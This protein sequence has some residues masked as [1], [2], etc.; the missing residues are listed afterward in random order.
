M[1]FNHYAYYITF[2]LSFS[3]IIIEQT[4]INNFPSAADE[5][6]SKEGAGKKRGNEI[7]RGE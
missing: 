6:M 5:T 1:K 3:F 4:T 2:Y 7:E